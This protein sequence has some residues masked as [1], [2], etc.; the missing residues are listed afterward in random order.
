MLYFVDKN[1]MVQLTGF[2]LLVAIIVIIILLTTF[3]KIVSKI[4]FYWQDYKRLLKLENDFVKAEEDF[5]FYLEKYYQK[6]KKWEIKNGF[7]RN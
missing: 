1:N 7:Y 5:P 4:V 3:Y 2:G 6:R